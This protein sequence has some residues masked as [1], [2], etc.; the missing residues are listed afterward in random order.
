MGHVVE[1]TATAVEEIDDGGRPS[2]ATLGPDRLPSRHIRSP[3]KNGPSGLLTLLLG[4]KWWGMVGEDADLG[5]CAS[6]I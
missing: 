5:V 3:R 1:R 6:K 2:S 4:L